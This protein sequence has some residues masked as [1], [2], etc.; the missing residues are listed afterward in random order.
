LSYW[1]THAS[2]LRDAFATNTALMV[3][4]FTL[5]GYQLAGYLTQ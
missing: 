4:G 3:G 1:R 5:L 2:Y